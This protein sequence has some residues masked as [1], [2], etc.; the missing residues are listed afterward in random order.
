MV[1]MAR[2]GTQIWKISRWGSLFGRETLAKLDVAS[3]AALGS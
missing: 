2:D 3:L 1:S